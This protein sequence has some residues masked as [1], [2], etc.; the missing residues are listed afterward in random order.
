VVTHL[1][2]PLLNPRSHD[3]GS[4]SENIATHLSVLRSGFLNAVG[5]EHHYALH[6]NR[7]AALER[8]G[9]IEDAIK[10]Y[11]EALTSKPDHVEA[12][13]NRGVGE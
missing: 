5:S 6:T 8:L 13:H 1:P 3:C 2:G 11:D 7:G 10:A 4:G 12:L 9:R